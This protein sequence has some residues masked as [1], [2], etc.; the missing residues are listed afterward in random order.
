M[1]AVL[2]VPVALA[3][4]I[5]LAVAACLMSPG[6]ALPSTLLAASSSGGGPPASPAP[7]AVQA[8]MPSRM[9]LA[10]RLA[11][12]RWRLIEWSRIGFLSQQGWRFYPQPMPGVSDACTSFLQQL[13]D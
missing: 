2:T 4:P 7:G 13:P 8:S 11:G 6:L 3:V 10:H 5:A 1:P 9:A 12:H